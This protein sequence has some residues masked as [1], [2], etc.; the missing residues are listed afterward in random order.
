M[1][2]SI[3]ILA[4]IFTAS[5]AFAAIPKSRE[6]NRYGDGRTVAESRSTKHVQG[7]EYTNSQGEAHRRVLIYNKKTGEFKGFSKL[8]RLRGDTQ[9]RHYFGR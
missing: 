4:S 1:R 5:S 3:I 8:G 6:G 9:E 7:R 2:V